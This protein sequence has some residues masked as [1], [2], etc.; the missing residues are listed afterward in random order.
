MCGVGGIGTPMVRIPAALRPEAKNAMLARITWS[1]L[2]TG[3]AFDTHLP[4]V[5]AV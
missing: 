5:D 3:R 1:V 4:E 2:N